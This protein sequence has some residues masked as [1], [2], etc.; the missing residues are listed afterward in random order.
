MLDSPAHPSI[1]TTVGRQSESRPGSRRPCF[2]RQV[3]QLLGSD[4]MRMTRIEKRFVNEIGHSRR[5]AEDAV[6]RLRHL[7]IQPGWS[8]LD[9][10]CGN[11]TAALHVADTFGMH[12]VGVDVDAQQIALAIDARRGRTDVRFITADAARLPFDDGQ[13]DIVATNKTTHH[14][15]QWL[16]AIAEMRR[17]LKPRGYFIYADLKTP[18]WLARVLKPLA[19]HAGVFT[20][21]DLD[22]CF[23]S[24]E[25]VHRRTGWLHYEA[26]L[27][28]L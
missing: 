2:G 20:G 10:G 5:V 23:A 11:G 1:K 4:V 17:V 12:V 28:K 16:S 25:Q 3:M 9:V 19:D 14:I 8:Y 7:P 24:L 21:A 26:I 6:R 15:P 13:F 22:R 27:Q 18:A